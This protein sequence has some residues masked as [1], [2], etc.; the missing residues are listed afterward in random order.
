M[1]IRSKKTVI[2]QN[3]NVCKFVYRG[4]PLLKT[5]KHF[6]SYNLQLLHQS[7]VSR[8]SV[9]TAAPKKSPPLVEG[10]L[11][12]DDYS[13]TTQLIEAIFQ[14]AYLGGNNVLVLGD[15]GFADGYPVDDIVDIVNGCI[16]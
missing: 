5:Q 1:D 12:T 11:N 13:T 15:F 14:T 9:I 8:L 3:V 2:Q 16:Y 4:L 10:S 6:D 7:Q